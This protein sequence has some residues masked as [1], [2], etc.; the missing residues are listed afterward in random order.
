MSKKEEGDFDRVVG[1]SLLFF[2]R[3]NVS[4]I[5]S[6]QSL[7]FIED[8]SYDT[9]LQDRLTVQQRKLDSSMGSWQSSPTPA[10]ESG[11][12]PYRTQAFR[13]NYVGH[14]HERSPLR[15]ESDKSAHS[16]SRTNFS[17]AEDGHNL[18]VPTNT[19]KSTF[20]DALIVNEEHGPVFSETQIK[21]AFNAFDLDGDRQI[22]A[23]ELKVIFDRIGHEVPDDLLDEMIM[24]LDSSKNGKVNYAEFASMAGTKPFGFVK[25][26]EAAPSLATFDENSLT[27]SQML[28][29]RSMD[30]FHSKKSSLKNDVHQSL[31]EFRTRVLTSSGELTRKDTSSTKKHDSTVGHEPS[32]PRI[33]VT[34]VQS[35]SSIIQ[36]ARSKK[37]RMPSRL[38]SVESA[39]EGSSR[40][41][42]ALSPIASIEDLGRLHSAK[43]EID[44]AAKAQEHAEILNFLVRTSYLPPASV[45]RLISLF[46][47]MTLS[48]YGALTYNDFLNLVNSKLPTDK[49]LDDDRLTRRMF[50]ILDK[51][52]TD[53]LNLNEFVESISMLTRPNTEEQFK[54]VFKV[55]DADEDGKITRNELTRILKLNTSSIRSDEQAFKKADE[56]LVLSGGTDLTLEGY[57]KLKEKRFSLLYPVQEKARK[58][59]KILA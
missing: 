39:E 46:V 27:T 51:D 5:G 11:K 52:G 18:G 7:P 56:L 47:S 8:H 58:I 33:K 21:H 36:T 29:R 57:L 28:S 17:A 26:H 48:Y 13:L 31:A 10:L 41:S 42:R 19:Y 40:Q 9:G 44:I 54:F 22:D 49:R 3:P 15:H 2:P 23:E 45:D 4:P 43:S 20:R 50:K 34:D 38:S 35:D 24:M 12:K 37:A 53:S 25:H 16:T 14:H 30:S 1:S 59:A 55:F 6:L 32:I